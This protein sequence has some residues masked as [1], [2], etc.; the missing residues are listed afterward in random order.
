VGVPIPA[1]DENVP[2]VAEI[3][4]VVETFAYRES[5]PLARTVAV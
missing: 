2:S 4:V 1:D 5:I 3:A